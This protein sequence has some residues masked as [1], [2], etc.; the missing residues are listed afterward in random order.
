V[1]AK[2]NVSLE[3]QAYIKNAFKIIS[4]FHYKSDGNR[5]QDGKYFV[6]GF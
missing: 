1:E 2:N 5:K 3:T 4:I 6:D